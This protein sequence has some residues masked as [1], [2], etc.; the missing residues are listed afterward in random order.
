M[1]RFLSL[2]G[3]AFGVSAL[4]AALTFLFFHGQI[5][6][7]ET[8]SD[9]IHYAVGTLTTSGTS[10]M[11]PMTDAVQLWTSLYVLTVWVYIVWVA[12]NHVSNIKF[13]RFG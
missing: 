2:L 5:K 4:F 7:A 9:Y 10:D 1:R 12:V 11:V 6:N 8:A 13:G 3:F